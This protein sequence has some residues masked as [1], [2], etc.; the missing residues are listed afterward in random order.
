MQRTVYNQEH[1]DFRAMIRDFIASEVVPVYD[2][3]FEAGIAPRDFYYKLG[4]LGIFGIEIPTEYGGAAIDS[5]KFQA[6]VTEELSRASVEDINIEGHDGF[7]AIGEDLVLGPSL[8]E[9][10]I[11]FDAIGHGDP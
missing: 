3:W 9:I 2:E 5:Y 7:I 6:I 11:Q 1:E 10:G 8:C 4:E